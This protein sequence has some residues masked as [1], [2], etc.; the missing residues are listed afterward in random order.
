MT[1][2]CCDFLDLSRD[3]DIDA[4]AAIRWLDGDPEAERIVELTLDLAD[5]YDLP[6]TD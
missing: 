1:L 4:D 3:S 5:P 2:Y 6:H